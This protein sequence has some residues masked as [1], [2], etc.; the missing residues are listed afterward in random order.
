MCGSAHENIKSVEIV[1]KRLYIQ[2][3]K[4]LDRS[5]SGGSYNFHQSLRQ[6]S[7]S[8]RACMNISTD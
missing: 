6:N 1:F 3:I 7:V 2:K 5:H 4:G 8:K